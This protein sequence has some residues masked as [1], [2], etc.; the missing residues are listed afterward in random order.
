MVYR[1]GKVI[2]RKMRDTEREEGKRRKRN[3]EK[4][5]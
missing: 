4:E 3:K 5:N 1:E 2:K